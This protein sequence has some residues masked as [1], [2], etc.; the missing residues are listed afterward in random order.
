MS[1]ED[2]NSYLKQINK[3]KHGIAL[4]WK[5]L[6]LIIFFNLQRLDLFVILSFQ[7]YLHEIRTQ[8]CFMKLQFYL[9]NI[10]FSMYSKIL[11]NK[12]KK[13]IGFNTFNENL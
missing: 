10:H 13:V 2:E 5:K 11:S 9:K 6:V 3:F 1:Y 7:V 12:N 8:S 4:L